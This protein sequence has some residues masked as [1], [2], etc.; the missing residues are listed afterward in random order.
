MAIEHILRLLPEFPRVS[1]S[2]FLEIHDLLTEEA[3]IESVVSL[4]YTHLPA[5]EKELTINHSL[6]ERGKKRYDANSLEFCQYLDGKVNSD[7]ERGEKINKISSDKT[8]KNVCYAER[9]RDK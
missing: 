2:G 9:R 5:T 7:E 6:L 8:V 3:G 1:F 4:V